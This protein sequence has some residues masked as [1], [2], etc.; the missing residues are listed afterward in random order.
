MDGPNEVVQVAAEAV[1]LPDDERVAL[2]E[3]LEARG[4]ARPVVAAAG[5]TVFVQPANG[6]AGGKQRVALQLE[7]LRAVR[8]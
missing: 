3:R 6:D 2:T 4:E 8:C 7:G 1:E 5:G